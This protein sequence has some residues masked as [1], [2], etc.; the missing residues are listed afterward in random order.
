V[1]A[2]GTS[3]IAGRIARRQAL[4]EAVRGAYAVGNGVVAP[5]LPAVMRGEPGA[6]VAL[7]DA[8][9]GYL[10]RSLVRVKVWKRD[11]KVIYSDVHQAIGATFE[12][13]DDV[14]GA[15]D[16]RKETATVSS[17]NDPENVTETD[18]F[19][20]LLE[21]YVPLAVADGTTVAFETYSTN[22]RLVAAEAELKA[23]LVP[24]SLLALLVL[25]LLQ[26]PVSIGLVRRYG[27]AEDER[28]RLLRSSLAASGRERRTIA[29][30]LHD[31][32]VQD[33]AGAAYVMGAYAGT[34]PVDTNP[35]S[36][37]LVEAVDNVLQ[38]SVAALRSMMVDIYP[39]E[40]NA[41]GLQ[42]AIE[43]LASKLHAK[44]GIAVDVQ[45]ELTTEPRPEVSAMVY[46]CTRECL[47]NVA[48][49]ARASQLR[50]NLIG[51]SEMVRLVLID[52]GVGL[53][54]TGTDRRAD[55]HIG[56]QLLRDAAADFGGEMR[57]FSGDIGGT[58]VELTLPTAGIGL[59]GDTG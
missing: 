53:P 36:R 26:L 35:R 56:L 50:L 41:D 4:A 12:L 38:E 8:L 19:N 11:G 6:V 3:I 47:T 14:I 32:L 58:T 48:K 23:Q 55:G 28:S 16:E 21:V 39:R 42:A 34:L 33:L 10:D 24:S 7:D 44:T 31:G 45:V 57:V 27:R 46:R 2:V 20:Q 1:V 43:D 17:L 37:K 18:R 25:L 59:A 22:T 54:E 29:R 40:L 52:N 5:L 49:H 30:D 15:I 51:D 13:H 9:R